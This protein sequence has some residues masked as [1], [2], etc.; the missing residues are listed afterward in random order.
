MR[1]WCNGKEADAVLCASDRMP[2]R[3]SFQFAVDVPALDRDA[4]ANV[5]DRI[6]VTDHAATAGNARG[7]GTLRLPAANAAASNVTK[8]PQTSTGPSTVP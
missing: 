7:L 4:V 3:D 5:L 2:P 8:D 6:L 1:I